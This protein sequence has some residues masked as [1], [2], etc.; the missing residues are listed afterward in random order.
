MGVCVRVCVCQVNL[1]GTGI[2]HGLTNQRRNMEGQVQSRFGSWL[3]F[4]CVCIYLFFF[5]YLFHF[6]LNIPIILLVLITTLSIRCFFS[7][8]ML[9]VILNDSFLG[10][11]RRNRNIG[12]RANILLQSDFGGFH[13]Y[14]TLDLS[15]KSLV[16]I[17]RSKL[18]ERCRWCISLH[19]ELL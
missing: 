8:C 1:L 11:G 6:L 5:C 17:K 12:F 19:L 16:D 13:S 15:K 14:L 10:R 4:V 18:R 2:S 7:F 3:S 9:N